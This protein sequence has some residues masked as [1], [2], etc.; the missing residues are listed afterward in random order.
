MRGIWPRAASLAAVAL[1]VSGCAAVQQG[2]SQASPSES[3]S[4]SPSGSSP[5]AT[6]SGAP[7]AITNAN[8]HPGEVSFT[9]KPNLALAASGGAGS[10]T[11]SVS[12]GSLPDGLTL[13]QNGSVYGEPTAAGT[14][15]F[16]VQVADSAGATA[17]I[18]RSVAIAPRIAA[19]LIPACAH[20]C[21]VEVG[22]ATVCG[23]YGTLSGGAGPFTYALQQ[24]GYVPTGTKV[25][26]SGFSLAGTFTAVA[27]YWQFTVL[28]TDSSGGAATITPTFYVF[29]H[30]SFSGAAKCFGDYLTPCSVKIPY[31]GGTPGGVP[32]VAVVGFGRICPTLLFCY[33]TPTA[34]PP[35]LATIAAGGYVTVSVLKACGYLPGGPAGCPSGW[36]GVVFLNLTDR[37]PCSAGKYCVSPGAEAVTVEIAG[38]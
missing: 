14:F 21:A 20:S 4:S 8:F 16:T 15:H 32:K 7:I 38:S 3:P 10:Y 13:T 37:S 12:A 2:Q 17:A 29:P 36:Y 6:P 25:S 33:P 5:A 1:I 31:S 34:P 24:G 27:K 23:T 18:A 26:K 9:Y 35:S 30:L 28:V 22:C 11:W 19:T